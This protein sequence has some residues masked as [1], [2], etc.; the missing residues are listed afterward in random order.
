MRD[1]YQSA[2][3]Q[4]RELWWWSYYITNKGRMRQ[5]KYLPPGEVKAFQ[6]ALHIYATKEEVRELNYQRLRDLKVPVFISN[7]SH[8]GG[9]NVKKA[10]TEEA[11]NLESK[12]FLAA[13]RHRELLCRRPQTVPNRHAP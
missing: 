5:N 10:T 9:A 1:L 4:H 6:D 2:S 12:L 13:P 7:A 3:N 8:E 11:G